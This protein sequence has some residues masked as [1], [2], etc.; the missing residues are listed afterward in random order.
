MIRTVTGSAWV[1]REGFRD[2]GLLY[3][4]ANCAVALQS[5]FVYSGEHRNSVIHVIADLDHT[6]VVVEPMQ[7]ANILLPSLPSSQGAQFVACAD[8]RHAIIRQKDY[9]KQFAGCP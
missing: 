3:G 9:F 8:T 1:L 2:A 6:L 7:S 5:A 4:I